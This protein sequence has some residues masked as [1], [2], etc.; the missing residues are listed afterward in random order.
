VWNAVGRR[1]QKISAEM[2][3][4]QR[5][6]YLYNVAAIITSPGGADAKTRPL[7]FLLDGL[8]IESTWARAYDA[9]FNWGVFEKLIS[10]IR[11]VRKVV[12]GRST[13]RPYSCVSPQHT[14]EL[15][16]SA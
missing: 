4:T 6:L 8:V 9:A 5:A 11:V 12:T 13:G 16:C 3:Y 1:R 7:S 2:Y 10:L 15:A 14:D